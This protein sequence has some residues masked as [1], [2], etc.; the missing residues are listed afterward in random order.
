MS[1][2]ALFPSGHFYSPVV[3]PDVLKTQADR[4]WPEQPEVLGIDFD[5]AAHFHVLEQLFPQFISA[6]DYVEQAPAE[7]EALEQFYVQNS[8]FSWL[9]ARAL[10]VLLRAWRPRRVIEVG[11]GYSSLL[12]A[13]VNQRHLDGACEVTCIEPYPRAFLRRGIAGLT[14]VIEQK[15]EDVPLSVFAQL[16]AGDILFIDSSHVAKT[17]SDVNSSGLYSIR[18]HV[19]APYGLKSFITTNLSGTSSWL[20]SG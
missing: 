11:S 17:G 1:N 13:D 14:R 7:D 18:N 20:Y 19:P 16:Q 6:F 2:D 9:D 15:V 4:I 12:I 3:D 5:D 10:F 8:Q